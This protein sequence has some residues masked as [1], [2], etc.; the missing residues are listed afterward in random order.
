MGAKTRDFARGNGKVIPARPPDGEIPCE[1]VSSCPPEPAAAENTLSTVQRVWMRFQFRWGCPPDYY[2]VGGLTL[3]LQQQFDFCL[4]PYRATDRISLTQLLSFLP[5]LYPGG[6]AWLD[7]RLYQVLCGKARCTV[8]LKD[9]GIVG[10]TIE[11]PKSGNSIKL[12]TIF[13]DPSVRRRGVGQLLIDGC[14]NQWK[15]DSVSGCY[16]TADHRIADHLGKL[17]TQFSFE[18]TGLVRNRYGKGRH[19]AIFSW[20]PGP[21]NLRKTID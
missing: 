15:R 13:V 18:K 1:E 8:A 12:S 16:V 11:T 14:H 21:D 5:D 4:R 10:V 20:K 19:E 17:L 9:G 6:F 3:S 2:L 7:R